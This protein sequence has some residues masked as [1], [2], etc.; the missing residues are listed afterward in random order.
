MR[1]YTILHAPALSFFSGA[2]YRDV[3]REWRGLGWLHLLFVLSISWAMVFLVW[4]GRLDRAIEEGAP[5]VLEQVPTVTVRGGVTSADVA[6]PYA[7]RDE[8]GKPV[9]VIDTTGGTADPEQA[10]IEEGL[11][12]ARTKLFLRNRRETRVFDL[13]DVPDGTLGRKDLARALDWFRR[14]WWAIAFPCF[15]GL[16]FAARAAQNLLYALVGQAIAGA[17]GVRLP[18]EAFM[19]LA[20]IAVTPVLLIDTVLWVAGLP[21]PPCAWQIGGVA[22]A[23][24]YLYVGIRASAEPPPG[25]EPPSPG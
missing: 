15:V 11:L 20:A 25:A 17:L 21:A 16:S 12:L 6:Q 8:Q 1:R 3:A 13:K 23:L 19:R 9:V 4:H 18:F 2:L 22:V 7:I 14:W 10:G 5:K 24:A